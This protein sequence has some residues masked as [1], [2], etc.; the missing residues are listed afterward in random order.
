MRDDALV[1]GSAI[2]HIDRHDFEGVPPACSASAISL[3]PNDVIMLTMAVRSPSPPHCGPAKRRP[4]Q[5]PL[6][7]RAARRR[8][9]AVESARR[10][11][12]A[13]ST[14]SAMR[15]R[16]PRR[17]RPEPS[18]KER[19]LSGTRWSALTT[20]GFDC[21]PR[22]QMR[23]GSGWVT[24]MRGACQ[25]WLAMSDFQLPFTIASSGGHV[26]QKERTRPRFPGASAICRFVAIT[27]A[28]S[29]ALRP[30]PPDRSRMARRSATG[31]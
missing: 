23:T 22:P 21:S 4:M 29:A 10:H 6:P 9:C 15:P 18:T 28:R 12:R 17:E 19:I 11:R 2:E 13:S 14:G 24:R 30:T 27:S 3:T 8:P 5:W 16:S 20:S 7:Q 25:A 26:A 31:R 1:V